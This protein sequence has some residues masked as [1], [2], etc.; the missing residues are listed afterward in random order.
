MTTQISKTKEKTNRNL[1]I[2]ILLA[3]FSF[4]IY[5]ILFYQVVSLE[6]SNSKLEKE[7]KRLED[8]ESKLSIL[9]KNLESTEKSRSVLSAY[10]IDSKD[11]VP[12]LEKL[13]DYAKDVGV[14]V[15][16][17]AVD[18]AKNPNR[19]NIS[20][21]SEG[22]FKNTYRFMKMVETAPFE[23]AINSFEVSAKAPETAPEKGKP[24]PPTV[25]ETTVDVSVFSITG[26]K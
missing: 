1:Y 9:K 2:A 26:I 14:V 7:T 3:V 13:E 23:I 20:F 15:T 8:E 21:T 4:S 17:T 18:L 24:I 22:Q 12:F 10:F 11:I 19:L 6:E 5:G 16:F 25:W